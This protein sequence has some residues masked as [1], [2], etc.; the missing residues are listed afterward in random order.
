VSCDFRPAFS[1]YTHVNSRKLL[2]FRDLRACKFA[3]AARIFEFTRA[4]FAISARHFDF[5]VFVRPRWVWRFCALH[6]CKWQNRYTD[7]EMTGMEAA[8]SGG[9]FRPTC[10]EAPKFRD[11]RRSGGRLRRRA[12]ARRAPARARPGG[13]LGC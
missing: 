9:N 13:P 8:E 5:Y 12:R 1:I 4:S 7:R 11:P 10:M 2:A 3:K 6:A